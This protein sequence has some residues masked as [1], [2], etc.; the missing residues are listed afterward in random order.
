VEGRSESFLGCGLEDL[1][2]WM[3]GGVVSA[4]P[5]ASL[6]SSSSSEV[7]RWFARRRSEGREERVGMN[8]GWV[9]AVVVGAAVVVVSVVFCF[10]EFLLELLLLGEVLSRADSFDGFRDAAA[11]IGGRLA[12]CLFHV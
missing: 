1:R 2:F 3:G 9:G 4:R 12:E 6:G 10:A 8:F 5:M 7:G 11:E